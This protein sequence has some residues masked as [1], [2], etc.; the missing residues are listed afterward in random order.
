MTQSEEQWIK[1]LLDERTLALAKPVA[2][3]RPSGIPLL[4]CAGREA[5]WGL[6]IAA[7][8][9]VAPLP[10]WTAL[11]G[12]NGAVLG[13]ALVAGQRVLLADLDA[14]ATHSPPGFAER[15][16]HLPGHLVGHVPSHVVVLREGN[17]GLAVDRALSV[18]FLDVREAPLSSLG[19]GMAKGEEGVLKNQDCVVLDAGAVA[20]LVQAQAGGG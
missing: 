10:P 4:I 3:D 6:P 5:L 18:T 8:R 1:A 12:R 15:P 14:L 7:I 19:W 11:P 9:R 20:A 13:L 2:P 16:G 17:V